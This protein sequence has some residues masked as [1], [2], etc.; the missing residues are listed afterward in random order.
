MPPGN[1]GLGRVEPT[2]FRHLLRFA[3]SED[4]YPKHPVPVPIGINWYSR[5]NVPHKDADGN[6][7]LV[8]PGTKP[9]DFGAREGGHEVCL[10]S[11]TLDDAPGWYTF[12]DQGSQ[13]ACVGFAVTRAKS[14][15]DRRLL[16]PQWL[17]DR[18]RELDEWPG[19][20]YEG[21][22]GR[23]AAEALRT[24]GHKQYRAKRP[25]MHWAIAV[26]RW[27]RSV[28]DIAAALWNP[29]FGRDAILNRGWVV[30]LNSWGPVF[31]QYVRIDLDTLD[32]LV[33]RERGD[34][35]I[36]TDR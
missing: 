8:K 18:A 23:G 19:E 15:V 24:L 36:F 13:G 20:D 16:D 11:E 12:F 3:I 31:P 27:A 7:W 1:R 29:T 33:F 22:S 28:E 30:M 17:Y 5:F 14:H 25:S 9:R 21:T 4:T 35:L 34:A 2:D 6:L 32:Q 26:Y 10:K